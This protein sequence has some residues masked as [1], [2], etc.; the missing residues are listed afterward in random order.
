[1]PRI[2]VDGLQRCL[3][4][5]LSRPNVSLLKSLTPRP[6]DL[7]TEA[8]AAIPDESL[9]EEL[10]GPVP[11]PAP[12]A[13][14]PEKS[15]TPAGFPP[16][17]HLQYLALSRNPD[18]ITIAEKY[19]SA[20]VL[21]PSLQL[22]EILIGAC[23]LQ[24]SDRLQPTAF[25]LF[26]EMKSLGLQPNAKIFHSLLRMLA[27]SPDYIRR[28]EVLAEMAQRW[29]ALTD[30]GWAW[31]VQGYIKDRQMEM[32]LDMVSER[33][34]RGLMVSKR[35]YL[36][37]VTKLVEVGEVEEAL[38]ILQRVEGGLGGEFW[39]G[40][41]WPETRCR[42]WYE[43]LNKAATDMHYNPTKTVWYKCLARDSPF[44]KPMFIPPSGVMDNV[45]R[46]AARNGDIEFAQDVI[47][48][49]DAEGIKLQ[50]HH[51][52]C[53]IE[54]YSLCSPINIPEIFS[55][56]SHMRAARVPPQNHTARAALLVLAGDKALADS[57]SALLKSNGNTND[58]AAVELVIA[59]Y[60]RLGEL[61]AAFAVYADLHT[62][63]PQLPETH[64]FNILL[65]GCAD[66]GGEK[67]LAL[68]TLSEM[69]AMGILPD[70]ATF[71]ALVRVCCSMV[72]EDAGED[73]KTHLW[74]AFIFLEEAAANTAVGRLG[75]DVWAELAEA[76]RRAGDE[77]R[78]QMVKEEMQRL[79]L[80]M[81]VREV[82]RAGGFRI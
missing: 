41:M 1:M 9:P 25:G 76:C 65:R 54:A 67:E 72:T 82:I 55:V 58:L 75:R 32:A 38:A 63:T 24:H 12:P 26:H 77:E 33:E 45:L 14:E 28:S 35:V 52:A 8:S 51:Y 39:V 36:E 73:A 5:S 74:D 61:D 29:F 20:G 60:C 78:E 44:E 18:V 16:L 15:E 23:A 31:V 53:L 3:C 81:K 7:S 40:V 22:Y 47:S 19:V 49:Y 6:R 34:R 56:L 62:L 70:R 59:A 13:A 50:E 11:V 69:K 21:K 42:M 57:A 27:R 66:L 10:T 2:R 80:E 30:E 48:L 46:C 37:L 68:Y 71:E 43:L 79:G 17:D 64:T 4:P